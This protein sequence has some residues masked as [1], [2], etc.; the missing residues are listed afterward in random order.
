[1]PRKNTQE[2]GWRDASFIY[3]ETNKSSFIVEQKLEEMRKVWS[4]EQS[5]L[6]FSY[7]LRGGD[8]VPEKLQ[9]LHTECFML[10]TILV[11]DWYPKEIQT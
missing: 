4:F 10:V 8:I 7:P 2:T 6:A 9:K 3:F 11:R 5:R 1:M